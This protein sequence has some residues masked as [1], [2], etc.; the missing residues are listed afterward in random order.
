MCNKILGAYYFMI[1]EKYCNLTAHP[2]LLII[3]FK[4]K[5]KNL[6]TGNSNINLY[7]NSHPPAPSPFPPTTYL[8]L[9]ILPAHF[10]HVSLL[11]KISIEGNY[12]FPLYVY[13]QR[14]VFPPEVCQGNL[15]NSTLK[16]H[17]LGGL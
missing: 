14:L 13:S 7:S 11:S 12:I 4:Y 8:I 1:L 15:T 6:Y 3:I 2:I 5:W 10:C 9:S 16:D 17:V